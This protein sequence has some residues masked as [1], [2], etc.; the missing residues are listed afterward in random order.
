MS[1]VLK[2]RI[3][4]AEKGYVQDFPDGEIAPPSALAGRRVIGQEIKKGKFKG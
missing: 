2:E 4:N 1:I 3:K